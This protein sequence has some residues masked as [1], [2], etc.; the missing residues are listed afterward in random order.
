VSY[1]IADIAQGSLTKEPMKDK[2][3][4]VSLGYSCR[5]TYPIINLQ[6]LVPLILTHNLTI[7]TY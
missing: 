4:I 6:Q 7:T 1:S 3:S 5:V 2:G